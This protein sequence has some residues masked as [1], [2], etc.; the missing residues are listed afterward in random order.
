MASFLPQLKPFVKKLW[1]VLYTS[2][3]GSAV[4]WVFKKQ[5]WPALTW[6]RI[7]HG[8]R[9]GE[10]VRHVFLVDCLLDGVVLEVDASTTGVGVACWY[11]DRR[12]SRFAPPN[13]F[14]STV[15]TRED[16]VLL[17]TVRGAPLHQATWEAFMVLLAIRHHVSPVLREKI[18]LVGDALGVWYGMVRMSAKSQKI[19]EVAKE[20]ALHLALLGHELVGIHVCSE[21]NVI[22]DALSRMSQCEVVLPGL[23]LSRREFLKP[24]RPSE[25]TCL[26][27]V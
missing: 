21:V 18:I 1:A 20:L 19:N 11:G 15:W 2:G 12:R 8:Q 26:K 3:T 5:V 17:H 25:W 9:Q 10:L 24:R 14:V 13:S 27:Y 16:E 7:F 22:A 6:L 4:K 23:R